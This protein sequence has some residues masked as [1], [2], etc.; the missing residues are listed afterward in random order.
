MRPH[1]TTDLSK[2]AGRANRLWPRDEFEFD[3]DIRFVTDGNGLILRANH[4]AAALTRRPK[5]F[6]AGKPLGLL[7]VDGHRPRFYQCL[8]RLGRG[9]ATETF[10]AGIHCREAKPRDVLFSAQIGDG[11]D[12]DGG[13]SV[14]R[15][16][17]RTVHWLVRD[18]AARHAAEA[19][20]ADLLRRVVAAQEEERHRVAR[21][22]HDS[23]G[24]YLAALNI[25]LQ[26]V[27]ETAG[28]A[29]AALLDRLTALTREASQEVHRIAVE[30]RPTA[31]DDNGL[32]AAVQNYV[33][34]WSLRAGVP[35]EFVATQMDRVRLPWE[36][37][38]AVFRVIQEALTNVLKYAGATRVSVILENRGD[39]LF[40][41][42]EDDGRGFDP[43][44]VLAAPRALGGLGLVGMR[45]RVTMLGGTFQIES[46]FGSGTTVFVRIPL[47][48]TGGAS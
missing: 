37:A 3:P 8:V 26:G 29:A 31:L 39:H 41:L 48:L 15:R 32:P 24:Q 13:R 40:A 19:A 21:E 33:E 23:L 47:P 28:P 34:E 27:R 6:L 11:D 38:T 2:P 46:S 42:V 25:G 16:A 35:A 44:A 14:A 1:E 18:V 30:L 43:D 7:V 10:E 17:A 4:A 22:L 5:E 45:E 36:V 12:G 9:V 20:Q